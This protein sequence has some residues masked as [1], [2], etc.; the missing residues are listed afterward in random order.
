MSKPTDRTPPET[1]TPDAQGPGG[2]LGPVPRPK[3]TQA[4]DEAART[5]ARGLLRSARDGTLAVLR[6][7]DG[8]PA[9]SRVLLATEFQGRPIL[10]LSGLSLHAKALDADPRCSLL[11]GQAGKG[12]PLAH[13]R[14]T[15]FATATRIRPDEADHAELKARMLS[16]HPKATLYVD[17]PDFFF[18]VLE[19]SGASLN[20]GFA[21]AFELEPGDLVDAPALALQATAQRARDHM[22]A[23]HGDSIDEIAASHGIDGKGWR[24]A[25]MDARGFEIVRG[26]AIRRIAFPAPVDAQAGGYRLAFVELVKG[27][28][29]H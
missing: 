11:L 19:P 26:D 16:R 5:Q 24:I 22:N 9:A 15:V 14:L 28:G 8:H 4:V 17:F 12:D 23:D 20:G 10:L 1:R 18:V 3:L 29:E 2:G 25:T 7:T 21:R 13:P 6:P 27:T